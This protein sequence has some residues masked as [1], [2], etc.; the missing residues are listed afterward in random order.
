MLNPLLKT[1]NTFSRCHH[2]IFND[3][4]VL[5]SL[6]EEDGATFASH[7]AVKAELEMEGE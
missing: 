1:V 5:S 3:N 7:V 4:G 6:K 2:N